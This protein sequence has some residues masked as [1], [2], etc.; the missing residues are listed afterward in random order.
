VQIK[1]FEMAD[2]FFRDLNAEELA[3]EIV[4]FLKR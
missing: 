1:V 3:E 4:G 2:H